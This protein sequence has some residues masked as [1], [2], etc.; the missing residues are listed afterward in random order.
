M[1]MKRF[2]A[3][4]SYASFSHI[5]FSCLYLLP[6]LMFRNNS[7]GLGLGGEIGCVQYENLIRPQC[8]RVKCLH[9]RPG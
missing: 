4:L 1:L 3:P 7:H 5:L 2:W 9:N 6:Y 8:G